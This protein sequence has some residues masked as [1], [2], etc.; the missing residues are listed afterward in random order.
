M[1][2]NSR[3]T[4][5]Q[6]RHSLQ[7]LIQIIRSREQTKTQKKTHSANQTL[8]ILINC[9]IIRELQLVLQHTNIHI[10][11]VVRPKRCLQKK[12]KKKR[13]KKK[14][15]KSIQLQFFHK[16]KTHNPSQHLIQ[17]RPKT[18]PIHLIAILQ[19]LNHLRRQI[20]RSPTKRRR[21]IRMPHRLTRP[22]ERELAHPIRLHPGRGG[23]LRRPRHGGV[24][25]AP[26]RGGLAVAIGVGVAAVIGVSVESCV[27]AGVAA[28]SRELFG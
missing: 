5:P 26:M 4:Y 23:R 7:E 25:F 12:K 14:S 20:L 11:M 27:G 18:P 21:R 2:L 28:V 15:E 19:P 16:K 9:P 13:K 1:L 24:E 10:R 6:R 3:F 17:H 8:G 22:P